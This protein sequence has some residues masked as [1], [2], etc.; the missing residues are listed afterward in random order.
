VVETLS[1]VLGKEL[2]L[3]SQRVSGIDCY[4][5]SAMVVSPFICG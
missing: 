5:L 1:F 3:E 2:Q 4:G